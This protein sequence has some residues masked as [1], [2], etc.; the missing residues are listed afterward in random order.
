MNSTNHMILVRMGGFSLASTQG[1]QATET[2]GWIVQAFQHRIR[3]KQ[4]R[5]F[6]CEQLHALVPTLSAP[7]RKQALVL[8]RK[9]LAAVSMEQ[10]LEIVQRLQCQLHSFEPQLQLQHLFELVTK[11]NELDRS[12]ERC[13][14][15]ERLQASTH[16]WNGL[17]APLFR[18]ALQTWNPRFYQELQR[19]RP[20]KEQLREKYQDQ[21]ETAM[22]SYLY[23]AVHKTTP[24]GLWAW[25]GVSHVGCKTHMNLLEQPEIYASLNDQEI[26]KVLEQL[27]AT[28]PMLQVRHLRNP[29]LCRH[30]DRLL[31]WDIQGGY[32]Q[33]TQ[34][35]LEDQPLLLDLLEGFRRP[36]RLLDGLCAA[37]YLPEEAQDMLDVCEML[38]EGGLLVPAMEVRSS[39]RWPVSDLIEW[40]R[41]QGL[42]VQALMPL[43]H[44]EQD[45]KALDL[46]VSSS[47]G[48]L[49]E[50][51]TSVRLDARATPSQ[52]M[53]SEKDYQSLQAAFAT[54][55]SL[56]DGFYQTSDRYAGL[57]HKIMEQVGPNQAIP[58]LVLERQLKFGTPVKA[59]LRR[60]WV[61]PDDAADLEK[62]N[63]FQQALLE[64]IKGSQGPCEISDLIHTFELKSSRSVQGF[65]V[66]ASL[67]EG[68]EGQPLVVLDMVSEQAG[69][70][71]W[72]YAPLL[73]PMEKE[74]FEGQIE[75][76]LNARFAGD[77]VVVNQVGYGENDNMLRGG[78]PSFITEE[79]CLYN[80]RPMLEQPPIPVGELGLAVCEGKLVLLHLTT[81]RHL[82]PWFGS[83][84]TVRSDHLMAL[85]NAVLADQAHY[86]EGFAMGVFPDL[87]QLPHVPRITAGSLVVSRERWCVPVGTFDTDAPLRLSSAR[88]YRFV[89]EQALMLGLPQQV[90]A[91]H[92]QQDKPIFVD[93]AQPHAVHV[94]LRSIR[95]AREFVYFEEAL[96]DTATSVLQSTSGHRHA[97]AV[98]AQL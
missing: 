42:E 88:R 51:Q 13:H 64:R 36:V 19:V 27:A 95:Q 18:Q 28:D 8:R 83:S 34:C 46:K 3:L 66:V 72:R 56:V 81:G 1:L 44:L 33:L 92:D 32:T 78:C 93:F 61:H 2:H 48:P 70:L 23:A 10:L 54:Y 4:H 16:L 87:L 74:Q 91:C 73:S 24:H 79:I 59:N 39:Q 63:L 37:G 75:R 29:T 40:R 49:A 62:F 30:E 31:F 68:E 6:I 11:Q 60:C 20:Q 22:A 82:H 21:L 14:R 38:I 25:I 71:S 94:W 89:A 85:I 52:M 58:L 86:A 65:E 84:M 15:Q 12:I 98:C 45:L 77:R 76:A 55:L 26:R 69:R 9:L 50:I 97:F 47:T 17:D 7:L 43:Q 35:E 5:D 96:P 53:L 90:Y 80:K 41:L 57:K 67:A